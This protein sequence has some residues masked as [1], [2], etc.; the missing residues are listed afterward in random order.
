MR[1]LQIGVI[2]S[3]QDLKY[4]KQAVRAARAIGSEI[5][6]KQA[7]LVFGAEKD[8]M[9][10][11]T[12]AAMAARDNKGVTIGITYEKGLSVYEQSAASYVISTG[13]E[14]GGGREMTQSLSCDAIVAIA[15]GSGT[16]N[17]ICVAYQ[18]NI[19]VVVLK[20]YGGWA[21]ELA[22]KY[23][24][25]RMRYQLKAYD[26]PEKAVAK[27]MELAKRVRKQENRAND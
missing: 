26:K 1:N 12:E 14:R 19:P 5:A 11:S 6:K 8:G 9:S 22:G 15:G 13:M 24:D 16:L 7:C 20:G 4:N 3:C 23:L 25:Q 17:E 10:L 21:D 2:G 27:A 18:A